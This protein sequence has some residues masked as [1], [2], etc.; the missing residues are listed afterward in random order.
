MRTIGFVEKADFQPVRVLNVGFRQ[1]ECH[2]PNV[3][4]LPFAEPWIDILIPGMPNTVGSEGMH[5]Q[6]VSA[7]KRLQKLQPERQ[8]ATADFSSKKLYTAGVICQDWLGR[9]G[10]LGAFG[11]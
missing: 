1:F 9:K 6:L 3:A 5:H 2:E 11:C 8:S 4:G 10:F 7:S